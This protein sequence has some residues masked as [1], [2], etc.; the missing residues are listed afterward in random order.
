MMGPVIIGGGGGGS[1]E[2]LPPVYETVEIPVVGGDLAAAIE[3]ARTY[4]GR[5]RGNAFVVVR[6][7]TGNTVLSDDVT[8]TDINMPELFIFGEPSGYVQIDVDGD[9]TVARN[10]AQESWGDRCYDVTLPVSMSERPLSVG[11]CLIIAPSSFSYGS[12]NPRAAASM[13]GPRPIVDVGADTVTVRVWSGRAMPLEDLEGDPQNVYDL[14]RDAECTHI[15]STA[16]GS[17]SFVRCTIGGFGDVNFCHGLTF[18]DTTVGVSYDAQFDT[19]PNSLSL[20]STR[21]TLDDGW[22]FTRTE[23]SKF[24]GW[25][26]IMRCGYIYGLNLAHS[27]LQGVDLCL[28]CGSSALILHASR[29][30]VN[31]GIIMATDSWA[32]TVEVNLGSTLIAP[33]VAVLSPDAPDITD[34]TAYDA[35]TALVNGYGYELVTSPA[36]GIVS[37]DGSAIYNGI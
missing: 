22:R 3:I 12:V 8:V 5:M 34:V 2:P 35:S 10:E 30:T 6:F 9:I 19:Y 16:T 18:S 4:Q 31:D 24:F 11:D 26:S 21:M 27:E 25:G 29:V 33:S 20:I 14:L 28:V 37:S 17:V 23:R 1:P 36:V 15:R 7:P 13:L 32:R